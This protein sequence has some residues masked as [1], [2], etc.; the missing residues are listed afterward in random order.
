MPLAAEDISGSEGEGGGGGGAGWDVLS[1][2]FA[3]LQGGSKLKDWDRQASGDEDGAGAAAGA[4]S[5]SEED[6]D[7]AW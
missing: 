4:D 7:A 5:S 6:G 1:K 3:G 2:D